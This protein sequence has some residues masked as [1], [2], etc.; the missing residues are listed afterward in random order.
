M[1][2]YSGVDFNSPYLIV[3]SV[4]N[5]P[6]QLQRDRGGVGKISLKGWAY[7]YLSANFQNCFFLCKHKYCTEK[8]EGRGESCSYV[9]E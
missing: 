9:F 6:P 4:D 7:L 2:P 1:G 8:G 3:N 5:F